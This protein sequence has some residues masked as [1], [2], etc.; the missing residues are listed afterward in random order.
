MATKYEIEHQNDPNAADLDLMLKRST[1]WPW[2][3]RIYERFSYDPNIVKRAATEDELRRMEDF[4]Q[5]WYIH[6]I[7]GGVLHS[8]GAIS[9]PSTYDLQVSQHGR[10]IALLIRP[11][12]LM[13]CGGDPGAYKHLETMTREEIEAVT[14]DGVT[15]LKCSGSHKD[16][17]VQIALYLGRRELRWYMPYCP[18]CG[19]INGVVSH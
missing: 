17:E 9:S 19:L 12:G 5:R 18:G 16:S 2:R 11:T 1:R 7:N 3:A 10:A 6:G 15:P 14:G 4:T 13:G 8:D